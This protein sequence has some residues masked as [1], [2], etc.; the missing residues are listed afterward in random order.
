LNQHGVERGIAPYAWTPVRM[1][2]LPQ[3]RGI[4]PYA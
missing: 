1:I 2:K 3:E 4:S